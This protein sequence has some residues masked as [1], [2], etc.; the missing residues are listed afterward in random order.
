MAALVIQGGTIYTPDRVLDGTVVVEDGVITAVGEATARH[1]DRVVDAGG[2]LVAPGFLDLQVNGFA[3]HS[4]QDPDPE[5][6]RRV[7]EALLR[8][9]VTGFLPTI[10]T[11]TPEA[12]QRAVA[13]VGAGL[14]NSLALG[15][16][17]EGPFISV[18]KRG[19]HPQDQIRPYDPAEVQVWWQLSRGS[20]RMVT[21]APEVAWNLPAIQALREMGLVVAAG[22]SNATYEE[23]EQAVS[24]GTSC[25]THLFNGMSGLHHRAPGLAGAALALPGLRA[26]LIAD[27]HHVHAGALRAA[28]RAKGAGEIYLVTDAVA[29]AGLPPGTYD[30][31]GG[32]VVSDGE[33]VRTARD[34]SLAGSLLTMDRAVANMVR[35][36]GASLADA[37]TMATRTPADV[38][39]L[40]DR[41]RIQVGARGDLVLLD[42]DLRVV[43][44]IVG[45]VIRYERKGGV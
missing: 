2:L 12:M 17:V 7:S 8:H 36:A 38:L 44:T 37:L 35:L 5:G 40:R 24:A 6:C 34:G 25:V 30:W 20:L 16:H 18:A 43:M 39:G 1:G 4:F 3:G 29:A 10:V 11:N 45:G 9:G 31:P 27:G 26:G 19:A 14:Q 21:L 23:A 22:H 28:Y 41:G 15:V 33:T 13:A 32:A 42:R